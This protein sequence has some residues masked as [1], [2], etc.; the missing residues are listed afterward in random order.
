LL[1]ILNKN[2]SYSAGT[3]TIF[4]EDI[5]EFADSKKNSSY[6]G[7]LPARCGRL[8]KKQLLGGSKE[9]KGNM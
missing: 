1:I 4:L 6:I 8:L 5:R 7:L 3:V 9:N 2:S